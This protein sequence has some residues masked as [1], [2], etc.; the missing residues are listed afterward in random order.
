MVP[1]INFPESSSP[2]GVPLVAWNL[3]YLSVKFLYV[4][5]YYGRSTLNLRSKFCNRLWEDSV[6]ESNRQRRD[7]ICILF[8]HNSL[9]NYVADLNQTGVKG[10]VF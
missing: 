7:R 4:Q 10:W 3:H 1:I 9:L 2:C 5:R 6:I 8:I